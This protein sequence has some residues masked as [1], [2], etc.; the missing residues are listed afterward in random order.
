[1]PSL[2]KERRGSGPALATLKPRV[3]RYTEADHGPR[4]LECQAPTI[5]AAELDPP[6]HPTCDPSFPGL[7]AASARARIR[8]ARPARPRTAPNPTGER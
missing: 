1:M 4:C 7:V 5:A 2:P 3:T 6:I 8:A